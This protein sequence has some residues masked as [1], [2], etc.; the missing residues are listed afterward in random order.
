MIA[1]VRGVIAAASALGSMQKSSRTSTMTTS[2]RR[3][4]AHSAVAAYV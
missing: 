2:A 3:F 4:I 1:F